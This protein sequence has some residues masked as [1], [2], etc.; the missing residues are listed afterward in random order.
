MMAVQDE[1]APAVLS[2]LLVVIIHRVFAL[3]P[4]SYLRKIVTLRLSE[5]RRRR[6]GRR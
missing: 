2:L 4:E 6:C 3:R 5:N 1:V